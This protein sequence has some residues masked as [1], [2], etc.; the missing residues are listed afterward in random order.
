[1]SLPDLTKLE[2]LVRL[3]KEAATAEEEADLAQREADNKRQ[4][5][6]QKR[7]EVRKRALDALSFVTSSDPAALRASPVPAAAPIVSVPP[8]VRDAVPTLHVVMIQ[9]LDFIRP[10]SPKDSGAKVRIRTAAEMVRNGQIPKDAYMVWPQG[11]QK[12][13]PTKPVRE[14]QI[15]LGQNYAEFCKEEFP[16][17]HD[18][19]VLQEALGWGT[20]ND[21]GNG[22][23]MILPVIHEKGYSKVRFHL[24]TDPTHMRRV[25]S[26]WNKIAPEAWLAS[27]YSTEREVLSAFEIKR[28]EPVKRFGYRVML[29]FKR[30]IRV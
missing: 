27:F 4:V 29:L 15:S 24:V 11:Y 18:M 28:L 21:I 20:M 10:L 25:R 23:R 6:A 12:K 7:D 9:T 5:A 16:E 13:N 1:M 17:F 14:S 19:T 2:L 8:E 26:V 3:T 22:C 30:R